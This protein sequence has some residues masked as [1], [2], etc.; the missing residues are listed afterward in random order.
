MVVSDKS[1]YIHSINVF[2]MF[3]NISIKTVTH[4]SWMAEA[5]IK[6]CNLSPIQFPWVCWVVTGLIHFRGSHRGCLL[7]DWL[8]VWQTF[9]LPIY[10]QYLFI[11]WCSIPSSYP[12]SPHSLFLFLFLS[13]D[14]DTDS[15]N[16]DNLTSSSMETI[17]GLWLRYWP[18]TNTHT[19]LQ[20]YCC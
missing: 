2:L 13:V 20:S 11:F 1:I 17:S 3:G 9:Y 18:K 7:N 14:I 19:G 5:G 8:T 16:I 12:K 15:H 6:V 10:L 4:W